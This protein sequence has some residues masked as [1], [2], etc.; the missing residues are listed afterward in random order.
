MWPIFGFDQS[1]AFRPLVKGTRL[2]CRSLMHE[3]LPLVKGTRLVHQS[4]MHEMLKI[5]N[6][7]ETLR[8]VQNVILKL[9]KISTVFVKPA[10]VKHP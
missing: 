8:L 2:V 5:N 3:M 7:S 6:N 4:L 1:L 9:E 10:M